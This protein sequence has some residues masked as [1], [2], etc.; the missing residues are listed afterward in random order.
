M[1]YELETSCSV[2]LHILFGINFA[3]NILTQYKINKVFLL[4]Q[5]HCEKRFLFYKYNK[6]FRNFQ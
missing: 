2:E 6:N 3:N 4:Y 5:I 1:I